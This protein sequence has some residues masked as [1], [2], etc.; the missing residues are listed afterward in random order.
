[1][2]KAAQIICW[3]FAVLVF[4]T[5]FQKEPEKHSSPFTANA[6]IKHRVVHF[7]AAA[8]YMALSLVLQLLWL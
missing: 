8:G 1:M 3:I 5:A 4:L 2:L 6:V 7:V